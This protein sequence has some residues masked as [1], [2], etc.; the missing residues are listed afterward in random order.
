M[1]YVKILQT[2]GKKRR[3]VSK[4]STAGTS[5]YPRKT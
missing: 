2:L 3:P 4:K 1:R 5:G